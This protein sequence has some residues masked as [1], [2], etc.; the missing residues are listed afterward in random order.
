MNGLKKS[1]RIGGNNMLGLVITA[2][3]LFINYARLGLWEEAAGALTE[4]FKQAEEQDLPAPPVWLMAMAALVAVERGE[5]ETAVRF[6]SIS[7]NHPFTITGWMGQW[8]RLVGLERELREQMDEE[9]FEV[10]WAE[11]TTCEAE[12]I[13]PQIYEA[14][15]NLLGSV[16]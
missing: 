13:P 12:M 4:A 8:P 9:D 10:A 5:L 16:K 3:G 1:D 7:H 2:W 11:G 14:V 15:Y 6:L